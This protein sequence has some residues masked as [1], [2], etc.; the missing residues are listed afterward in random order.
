MADDQ[1]WRLEAVLDAELGSDAL[2]GVI[3]HLLASDDGTGAAITHN[4][5]TLFAY[6]SG[7]DAL[8]SARS[9]IERVLIGDGVKANILVSHWEDGVGDW[10]QV[11]PPLDT[12]AQQATEAVLADAAEVETRTGVVTAGRLSRDTVEAAMQASATDLGLTCEV[13]EHRHLLTAQLSFTVTGPR[14]RVAQFMGGL[15]EEGMIMARTEAG[16]FGLG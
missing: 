13:T 11:D 16:A 12:E 1:D 3:Q 2:D 7:R 10:L 4:E 14:G 8:D 9:R 6:A 15:Q 5:G